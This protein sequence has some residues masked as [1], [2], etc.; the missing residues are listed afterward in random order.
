M[1]NEK[2]DDLL[3]ELSKFSYK[4]NFCH[5]PGH[6]GSECRKKAADRQSGTNVEEKALMIHNSKDQEMKRTLAYQWFSVQILTM[7]RIGV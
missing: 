4:C 5:K 1:K 3:S 6:R 2:S 7:Q